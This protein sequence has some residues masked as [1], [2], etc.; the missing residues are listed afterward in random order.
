MLNA[1]VAQAR[2]EVMQKHISYIGFKP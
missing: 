1:L 2:K